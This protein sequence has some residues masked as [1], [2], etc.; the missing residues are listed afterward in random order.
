MKKYFAIL[1][2]VVLL[3]SIFAGCG[4][5]KTATNEESKTV[6][7]QEEKSIE[8]EKA[9]PVTLKMMAWTEYNQEALEQVAQKYSEKNPNVK[10][11]FEILDTKQYDQ[12]YMARM[13]A[14]EAADIIGT[15]HTPDWLEKYESGQYLVNLNDRPFV[16]KLNKGL[17][18]RGSINGKMLVAPIATDSFGVFYNK[19]IFKAANVE[20]PF[21]YD[22]FVK[23][24]EKIKAIGKTPIAISGKDAWEPQLFLFQL[25][26]KIGEKDPLFFSKSNEGLVKW[27]ET[28]EAEES[29]KRLN[30]LK[31]Y[32]PDNLMGVT[33]EKAQQLFFTGEAAMMPAGTW[34]LGEIRK[35]N[36]S[37]DAG[38]M[39]FPYSDQK[40]EVYATHGG[41]LYCVSVYSKSENK[42]EALKYLDFMFEDEP[43]KLYCEANKVSSPAL[44]GITVEFDPLVK[45]FV[46]TSRM[47][48][49]VNYNAGDVCTKGIQEMWI[50]AKTPIQI[51]QEMDKDVQ[52]K[53]KK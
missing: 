28:P 12:I 44:Q 45:E 24:C 19:D 43:Y 6:E 34:F 10:V 9:E 31:D 35:A 29:L 4:S 50:G 38:Y 25:W 15:R 30:D 52:L 8:T 47:N 53:L 13:A 20:E 23:A 17:Q 33:W 1:L 2:C 3:V 46:K 37:F 14:G 36:V 40:Q 26:G 18:E 32:Y 51:L 39:S 49:D 7:K 5:N 41:I 42:D 16:S 22:E 11:E 27:A 21:T 48:Y